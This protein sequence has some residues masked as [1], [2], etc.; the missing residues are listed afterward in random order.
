VYNNLDNVSRSKIALVIKFIDLFRKNGLI[1]YKQN[2]YFL[3]NTNMRF[4]WN[5]I[6]R[7]T[8]R[9]IKEYIKEYTKE[10]KDDIRLKYLG[11]D[12]D[13]S[14]AEMLLMVKSL[15]WYFR[16]VVVDSIISD[17]I[18]FD[19]L[20][21]KAMSVG[22][23]RM[24]SDYDVTLD[25]K[26]KD[27]ARLIKKYNRFIEIL[28]MDDSEG[29]FDTNVYGVSFIKDMSRDVVITPLIDILEEKI[30]VSNKAVIDA[31]DKEHVRC[32]K[33]NYISSDDKNFIISQHIWAFIKLLLRLN[34]VQQQ[35]EE[36]FGL[37]LD[38]L[39]KKFSENVYYN[40]A[41]SFM[42]KYESDTN[43]YQKTVGDAKRFL[44]KEI[45]GED[46]YFVSNF[47]S[48]V[49]FNGSETYLT[50]GAFLDVVVNSQMCKGRKEDM[51]KMDINSYLDSFVENLSDLITHYHKVK[52]LNRAKDAFKNIETESGFDVSIDNVM[53]S[54]YINKKFDTIYQLQKN[55]SRDIL[56]CQ[57]FI[58]IQNILDCI[59]VVCNR[60]KNWSNISS[61]ELKIGINKF[62]DLDFKNFRVPIESKI[63]EI[64]E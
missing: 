55:C 25:G 47:I 59:T 45:K 49:N 1:R 28:F 18:N 13:I 3:L 36:L 34:K 2:M 8:I 7:L 62:N 5:N 48:Y 53:L 44:G 30:D 21:I 41:V 33:F 12:E 9:D 14:E 37:F 51:V 39:S 27:N 42:N 23:T 56:Q 60:Y 52:Y 4:K 19:N 58:I 15:F 63:R 46:K 54:E 57:S 17:L 43:Y 50:N 6:K 32:G 31:F 35:D 38:D 20:D 40:T 16:K 11:K 26:Y 22:S 64:I 10:F 61:E 29:V 24:T